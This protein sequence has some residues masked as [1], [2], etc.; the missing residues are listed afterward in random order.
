MPRLPR[1]TGASSF[2]RTV[3][4]SSPSLGEP[5]DQVDGDGDHERAEE[6]R[7]ECVAHGDAA[8]RRRG[9][10]DVARAVGHPDRE[11]GEREVA[12]GGV[13]VLVEVEAVGAAARV[14]GDR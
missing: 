1:A 12:V 3:V 8:R 14:E 13:F 5:R 10:G 6:V 7:Q 4:A 9:L 11:G 2:A